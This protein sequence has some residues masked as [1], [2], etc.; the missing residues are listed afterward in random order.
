MKYRADIDG[1]RALAILSV[2]FYHMFPAVLPGGF[3][4]VDIF[5]VISGYLIGSTIISEYD[6]GK[7]S[8]I[9]F[10][11]R[12]LVRIIPPILTLLFTVG[13]AGY[14]LLTPFEFKSLG[15]HIAAASIFGSNIQLLKEVNYFAAAADTKPLLHLWSL[16][17]EEQFYLVLPLLL[18]FF[19]RNKIRSFVLI[20]ILLVF[21]FVYCCYLLKFKPSDAFFRP[22]SRFW[23][24]LIGVSL[25]KIEKMNIGSIP[26]LKKY[27]GIAG[28][29]LCLYGITFLKGNDP[30]PGV[31]ALLPTIGAFLIIFSGSNGVL[32]RTLFSNSFVVFIGKISY[33]FY[34]WHWPLLS[35]SH[36]FYPES[37]PKHVTFQLMALALALSVVTYYFVEKPL[38]K[39]TD[40]QKKYVSILSVIG[41]MMTFFVGRFVYKEKIRQHFVDERTKEI[42]QT[43]SQWVDFVNYKNEIY[44]TSFEK[45]ALITRGRGPIKIAFVGDSHSQQYFP[46]VER[47]VEKDDKKWTVY[48]LTRPGC[49]GLLNVKHKDTSKKDCHDYFKNGFDFLLKEKINKIIFSS[50][51]GAYFTNKIDAYVDID[52]KK[53]TLEFSSPGYAE[54]MKGL[55]NNLRMFASHG[56]ETYVIPSIPFGNEFQPS[57]MFKR[58]LSYPSFEVEVKPFNL[59]KFLGTYGHI[60]NDIKAIAIKSHAHIIDPIKSLCGEKTCE[61]VDEKGLPKYVDANHFRV[62]YSHEQLSFLNFI[63]N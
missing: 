31:L 17:I 12:R 7:F 9:K 41:L 25:S 2:V 45:G 1:L 18:I 59:E 61:V 11:Q 32:N 34:L 27:F 8:F 37:V 19:G 23:E 5:F 44:Y 55:E 21:S 51:W 63:F 60:I 48:F 26:A 16:G 39:L 4:G 42:L 15:R 13:I 43:T 52:G 38:K 29:F 46:L 28:F 54:A 57:A 40:K 10:Y 53:Q 22:E 35:I 3:A 49:S 50:F 6:S 33:S 20:N 56:V 14:F 36:L 58:S 30:Y 62:P 47:F 24:L